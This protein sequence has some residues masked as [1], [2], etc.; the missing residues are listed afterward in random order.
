[1]VTCEFYILGTY[2]HL[3]SSGFLKLPHKSTL[4]KYTGF[5]NMSTGYNYDVNKKFI[6]DIKLS[7]LREHEKNVSLLFDEMKIKSGLV[8][9]RSTGRLVGFTDLG[10]VNNELD[11]FN[12]FIKQGCKEPDLATHVLTLMARG[13]FN[14]FNYPV[15][16][17]ASVGFDS[18]QLYPVVWEG[19][20]ILEGLGIHVRAFVSDGA[21]PNRKFFRLHECTHKENVS[22]DNVVY[23]TWNRFNKGEKIFFISDPPHLIKTLRNNLENSHGHHNTRQLIVSVFFPIVLSFFLLHSKCVLLYYALLRVQGMC[24]VITVFLG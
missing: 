8:F 18:D 9:S 22:I 13:L 15:G 2:K 7:T 11:D 24:K 20:G 3:R 14:Y 6:D 21:S 16:Y 4:L 5:T 23:W 1:M 19:V 10:D 12:R 17:F